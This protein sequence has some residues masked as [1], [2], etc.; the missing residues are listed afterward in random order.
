MVVVSG[1]THS[2]PSTALP[3]GSASATRTCQSAHRGVRPIGGTI[4]RRFCRCIWLHQV[5]LD[6]ARVVVGDARARLAS[7]VS[8]YF[9][10]N[11]QMS[12]VTTHTSMIDVADL[13]MLRLLR[14]H[15]GCETSCGNG[16]GTRCKRQGPC[17]Q[18]AICAAGEHS[19][20]EILGTQSH[21]LMKEGVGKTEAMAEAR[22]AGQEAV[23][24]W[25]A[26]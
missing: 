21:A 16:C 11:L 10:G 26:S 19:T 25:M 4:S 24:I 14:H 9:G 22:I 12:F 13:S 20:L 23:N 6:C 7:R 1:T 8:S 3:Q 2:G 17:P 18:T 5:P 15:P